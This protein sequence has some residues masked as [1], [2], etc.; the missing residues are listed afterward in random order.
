MTEAEWLTCTRSVD[1]VFALLNMEL[2]K[3]ERKR[4]LFSVAC[5]RRI[6]PLLDDSSQNAVD[7]VERFADG[8]APASELQTAE[9]AAHAARR[10]AITNQDTRRECAADAAYNATFGEAQDI[11]ANS[12]AEACVLA[13]HSWSEDK[14]KEF[15]HQSDLLRD[16]FGN[17]F[18]RVALD[19]AWRSVTV[20]SL[21]ETIY[22]ERAF[23]RL[24][25]LADALE[26]AGCTHADILEHCRGPGPHARGCWV[27]DLV[28]GRE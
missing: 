21:A 13:E 4:R 3:S 24:P 20:A 9:E 1:L 25:I 8:N 27:V 26:D 22:A 14:G 15:A 23:D 16:I 6:W 28:L 5:C 18:R 2:G 10:T 19:P 7:S 17:P 11:V 12:A